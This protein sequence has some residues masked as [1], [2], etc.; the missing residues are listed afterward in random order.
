M[1]EGN[2]ARMNNQGAEYE[3]GENDAEDDFFDFE[4]EEVV[5]EGD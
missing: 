4:E 5:V 1:E 2:R 3:A